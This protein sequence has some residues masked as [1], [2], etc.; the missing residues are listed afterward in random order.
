MASLAWDTR[1]GPGWACCTRQQLEPTRRR[2]HLGGSRNPFRF[3]VA[4]KTEFLVSPGLQNWSS[5]TYS[6][7]Y[8]CVNEGLHLWAEIERFGV[9][10]GVRSPMIVR[11]PV[12]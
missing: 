6:G 12:G 11:M 9:L 10:R 3:P 4:L 1:G 5:R 8:R 2:T 7:R